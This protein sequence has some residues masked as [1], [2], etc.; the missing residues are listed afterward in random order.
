VVLTF[1]DSL[2]CLFIPSSGVSPP[3]S[4]SSPQTSVSSTKASGSSPQASGS[5]P[6]TSR[7]STLASGSSTQTFVSSPQT[8][9]LSTQTSTSLAQN[10]H[11]TSNRT[12]IIG[13]LLG[14]IFVCVFVLLLGSLI[15][16][17]R[18]KRL[19]DDYAQGL[20]RAEAIEP[21]TSRATFL[22]DASLS[23]AGASG[24]SSTPKTKY[25]DQMQSSSSLTSPTP[26]NAQ[27]ESQS[28]TRS[29]NVPVPRRQNPSTRTTQMSG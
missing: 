2:D 6:Q 20:S 28:K 23:Q 10:S 12:T 26:A 3:A 29:D 24:H 19:R 16:R 21:F 1:E 11:P 9:I 8:S 5:S 15:T 4:V 7:S 18:R 17:R 25:T 27:E 22:S 14:G 13:A